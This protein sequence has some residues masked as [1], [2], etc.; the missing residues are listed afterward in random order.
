[1]AAGVEE[2]R[3]IW[4]WPTGTFC[5]RRF[6]FFLVWRH[7]ESVFRHSAT[8]FDVCVGGPKRVSGGSGGAGELR[9]ACCL[10]YERDVVAAKDRRRRQTKLAVR[11]KLSW[12][13]DTSTTGTA[14][15][16]EGDDSFCWTQTCRP[17][18][19][20]AAKVAELYLPVR[21]LDGSRSCFFK[22]AWTELFAL[23]SETLAYPKARCLVSVL[24]WQRAMWRAHGAGAL[25]SGT[26][27]KKVF[28]WIEVL[29]DYS[30][31]PR[32]WREPLAAM[33]NRCLPDRGLGERILARKLSGV[34]L[35]GVQVG[36]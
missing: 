22:G 27:K 36:G 21:A 4:S 11:P 3:P 31:M 10:L 23:R 18:V 16:N 19:R 17:K 15:A 6:F 25:T 1:L 35:W 30:G 9:Q 33:M 13:V 24:R 34:N 20:L 29:F 2:T 7:G 28:A 26:H 32:N 12:E 5:H 14:R 8:R